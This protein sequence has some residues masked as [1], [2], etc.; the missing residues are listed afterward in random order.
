MRSFDYSLNYKELDLRKHPEL[1]VIG[2]GEQGVLS[3]EPYKSE[4]LP[5][6]R[7][8]NR[9]VATISSETIFTMFMDYLEK[10]DFVGADMAR[11]F[12]QMGFTRARRYA[13]YEGEKNMKAR[14]RMTKRDRAAPMAEKKKTAVQAIQKR[15]L[16]LLYSRPSGTK[17]DKMKNTF[18]KRKGSSQ[19]V[20]VGSEQ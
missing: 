16:R 18:A 1:Y 11:K 15:R 3:V 4:I 2:R 14:C 9:D 6:W 19:T 20:S 8:K 17:P 5:H 10:N 7:F 13:N 12:L